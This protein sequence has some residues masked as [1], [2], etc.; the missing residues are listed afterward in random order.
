MRSYINWNINPKIFK[1]G[2]F[3]I[4][5]YSIIFVLAFGIG[6][7]PDHFICIEYICA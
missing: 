4:R 5:Y 7:V 3:A 2:G 1:I 6:Y